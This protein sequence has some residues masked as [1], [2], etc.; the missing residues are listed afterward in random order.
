MPSVG[1]AGPIKRLQREVKVTPMCMPSGR[2][3]VEIEAHSFQTSAFPS[4]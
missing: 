1:V 4:F 2:R 3:G